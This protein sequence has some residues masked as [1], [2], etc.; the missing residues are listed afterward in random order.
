MRHPALT[1]ARARGKICLDLGATTMLQIRELGAIT[2]S[3]MSLLH[4]AMAICCRDWG[5]WG[6]RWWERETQEG[7][8]YAVMR[9]RET[10]EGGECDGDSKGN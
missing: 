4:T 10:G 9:K 7:E 8:R 1:A 3:Q 6:Q 2:T 5:V